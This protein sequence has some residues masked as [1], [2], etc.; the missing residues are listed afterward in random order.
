MIS[1]NE[2]NSGSGEQVGQTTLLIKIY[3]YDFRLV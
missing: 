3:D 2:V 1:L